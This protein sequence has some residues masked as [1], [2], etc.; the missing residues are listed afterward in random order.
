MK[1]TAIGPSEALTVTEGE[2]NWRMTVCGTIVRRS[3]TLELTSGTSLKTSAP[4]TEDTG[5]VAVGTVG[6]ACRHS[7][8]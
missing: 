7:W 5:V 3:V 4:R 1:T 8:P 2:V 6:A